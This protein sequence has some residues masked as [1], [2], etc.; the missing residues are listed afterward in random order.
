MH[1]IARVATLA[2]L[3]LTLA[4]TSAG[5][6]SFG[7]GSTTCTQFL[8]AARGSDIL[9]YQASNWLLGYV[10]GMNAA[11]RATGGGATAM[12]LTNSQLLKSAGDYCQ[13]NPTSTIADAATAWYPSLPK[14]AEAPPPPPQ[15]QHSSGWTIDLGKAPASPGGRRP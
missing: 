15:Q 2:A 1:A 7:A 11:L 5:A 13:A 6:Q 9:Y 3:P 4:V 8:R 14:Q 12:N 10:S